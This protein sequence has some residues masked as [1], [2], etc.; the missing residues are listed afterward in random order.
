MANRLEARE[1]LNSWKEI[2]TFFERDERTVKRWEASRGLPVQ[3]VPG[4]ARCKVY[5]DTRALKNWLRQDSEEANAARPAAAPERTLHQSSWGGLAGSAAAIGQRRLSGWKEIA[6]FF[7]RD[8]CTV[9]RWES[10][11]GLP[12]HRMP[13]RSRSRVHADVYELSNWLCS[14][15]GGGGRP[16]D[17]LP[18]IS[19]GRGH[20]PM[21]LQPEVTSADTTQVA[22][23]MMTA[24]AWLLSGGGTERSG[25]M[26][27][28]DY[29][30]GR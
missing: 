6:S 25:S 5:A 2:A 27:P 1:R 24:A 20:A 9:K 14:A 7:E 23:A 29:E 28:R 3:R 4:A 26:E 15:A 17:A 11:R 13:G 30:S 21:S 19:A 8:E 16:L 18:D 10:K 22:L 12:V